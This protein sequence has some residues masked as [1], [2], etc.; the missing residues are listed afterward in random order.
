MNEGYIPVLLTEE[1]CQF[2]VEFCSGK[3]G[4]DLSLKLGLAKATGMA[5]KAVVR[6]TNRELTR[7]IDALNL[8]AALETTSTGVSEWAN[9]LADYLLKWDEEKEVAV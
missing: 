9:E 6:F 4:I 2:M 5:A 3:I 7:L 8:N 1:E